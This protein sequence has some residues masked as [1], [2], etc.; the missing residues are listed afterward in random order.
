ME[1]VMLLG[2]ETVMV[3]AMKTVDVTGAV[4]SEE[5][6]PDVIFGDVESGEMLILRAK[7]MVLRLAVAFIPRHL[8]ILP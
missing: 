7:R 4:E 1:T 8:L 5:L 6:D 2:M 3:L